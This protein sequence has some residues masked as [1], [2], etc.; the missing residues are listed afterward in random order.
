MSHQNRRSGRPRTP[1]DVVASRGRP[2]GQL[3]AKTSDDDAGS[4][5][6]YA[7]V[8][9][10][11]IVTACVGLLVFSQ[12]HAASEKVSYRMLKDF[13]WK[14]GLLPHRAYPQLPS[15][16]YVRSEMTDELLRR[17]LPPLSRREQ[18]ALGD[19]PG[20]HKRLTRLGRG[21]HVLG[22]GQ[23]L[24]CKM[25]NEVERFCGSAEEK[26]E[27]ITELLAYFQLVKG[28][29]EH[30]EYNEKRR[31]KLI[32]ENPEMVRAIRMFAGKSGPRQRRRSDRPQGPSRALIRAMRKLFE[33]GY[34]TTANFGSSIPVLLRPYLQDVQQTKTYCL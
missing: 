33:N 20:L 4:I 7:A 3:R 16:Q 21:N 10:F 22:F 32:A 25:N 31:S 1:Q 14:F 2:A 17:C 18:T 12:S 13:N 30:W 23:Y 28:S 19:D 34:L 6:T 24:T 26:G 11:V 15:G 27:L 29:I 8:G 5:L 9:I